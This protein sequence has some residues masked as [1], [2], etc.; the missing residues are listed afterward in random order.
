[1][2]LLRG[3]FSRVTYS[4]LP[5]IAPTPASG[6]SFPTH[7]KA[8]RDQRSSNRLSE[9]QADTDTDIDGAAVEV[10]EGDDQGGRGGAVGRRP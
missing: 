7:T 4:L 10:A 5:F 9:R 6:W 1:M 8:M 3:R 2:S